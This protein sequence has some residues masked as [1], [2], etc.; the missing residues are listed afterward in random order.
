MNWMRSLI[1]KIVQ[2]PRRLW[3][4]SCAIATDEHAGPGQAVPGWIGWPGLV[5]A[6]S[7]V[8]PPT[9]T[10]HPLQ[11]SIG[12]TKETDL[13]PADDT[14]LSLCKLSKGGRKLLVCSHVWSMRK[15]D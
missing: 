8:P 3:S 7:N 6:P 14:F 1:E 2:K 12:D 13:L 4:E 5:D 9:P 11:G 15:R 10:K